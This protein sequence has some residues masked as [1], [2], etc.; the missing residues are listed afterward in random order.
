MKSNSINNYT[1]VPRHYSENEI[2]SQKPSPLFTNFKEAQKN[3]FSDDILKVIF[4]YLPFQDLQSF[5][6]TSKKFYKNCTKEIVDEFLKISDV[7]CKTFPIKEKITEKELSELIQ[8]APNIE[9]LIT[10]EKYRNATYSYRKLFEKTITLFRDLFQ[11]KTFETKDPLS[12]LKIEK[13]NFIKLGEIYKNLETKRLKKI[14]S[15]VFIDQLSNRT[16]GYGDS[17]LGKSYLKIDLIFEQLIKEKNEIVNVLMDMMTHPH[18]Y[19]IIKLNKPD[20][21][22]DKGYFDLLFQ[23]ENPKSE[24]QIECDFGSIIGISIKSLFIKNF[25]INDSIVS[26]SKDNKLSKYDF[27]RLVEIIKSTNRVFD[28]TYESECL[29]LELWVSQDML[30]EAEEYAQE[31]YTNKNQISYL[32]ALVQILLGKD[33]PEEAKRIALNPIY[34]DYYKNDYREYHKNEYPPF[35]IV[36]YLIKQNRLIEAEDLYWCV[37]GSSNNIYKMFAIAWLKEGDPDVAYKYATLI[38]NKKG[39]LEYLTFIYDLFLDIKN[40][41]V[42]QN[43]IEMIEILMKELNLHEKTLT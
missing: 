35:L 43:N 7:L 30:K 11:K 4:S 20:E 6:R 21:Y 2:Q 17:S 13:E 41:F 33:N 31:K 26:K 34:S 24:F 23:D 19:P 1:L 28:S 10:E 12:I 37:A 29:L 25:I 15:L 36:E 32:K 39:D 5:S 18:V 42:Q 3:G 38:I 14:F 27:N 9:K 22:V 40:A 8:K 16:F